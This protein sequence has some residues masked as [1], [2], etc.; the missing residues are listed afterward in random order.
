MVGGAGGLDEKGASHRLLEKVFNTDCLPMNKLEGSQRVHPKSPG[1]WK[2]V[3]WE[4][5]EEVARTAPNGRVRRRSGLQSGLGRLLRAGGG[6]PLGSR[7]P[8][9]LAGAALAPPRPAGAGRA[10]PPWSPEPSAPRRLELGASPA[11]P[12]TRPPARRP[13]AP[14]GHLRRSRP[15]LPR[16]RADFPGKFAGSSRPPQA[17]SPRPT[18]A[19]L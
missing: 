5:W 2:C 9:Q 10:D 3:V 18:S 8:C 15:R 11:L 14:L 16:R 12:R 1:W 4:R 6:T 13:G 19:K 17:A 7:S